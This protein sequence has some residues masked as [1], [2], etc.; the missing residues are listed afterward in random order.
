MHVKETPVHVDNLAVPNKNKIWFARKI[1]FME[2]IP[3]THTMYDR[4]DELFRFCVAVFYSRHV[5]AALLWSQ[6]VSHG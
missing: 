2:P 4:A 1:G 3:I 6:N 5:I